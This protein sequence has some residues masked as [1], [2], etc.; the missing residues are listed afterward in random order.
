V[1]KGKDKRGSEEDEGK[2]K[3]GGIRG[4]MKRKRD[5]LW[6]EGVGQIHVHIHIYVNLPTYNLI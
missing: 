2:D 1:E 6:R 4:V 3:R 5:K